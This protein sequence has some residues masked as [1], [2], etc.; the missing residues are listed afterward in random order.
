[1]DR[2]P[3]YEE[4]EK[5][6]KELEKEAV[7]HK[8]AEEA[9]R[10]S[11]E[12]Y[13]DLYDNAPVM[14]HTIDT[15]GIVLECNQTEADMLGYSKEEIIGKP[16]YAFETKEYQDLAP[17]AL[18]EGMEKGHVVGER[19]FVRKD[20]TIIDTA[21][22][23][24]AIY[25]DSGQVVG[26]RSTVTDITHLKRTQEA[27]QESEQKY[28]TITESSLTGIF[29]HQDGRYVFVNDR[30]AEIHD[31]K[32]EELLGKQHLSLVHPDQREIVKQRASKRLKGEAVPQRY[33]LKRRR[34]DGKTIWCETM[35]T[36]IQ[37]AG[38][39][40]IMGNM[41][42]LTERKKA[43]EA[44]RESEERYKAI[45]EGAAEGI[46]IADIE[47]MRQKYANPAICRMLG[48]SEQELKRMSVRD[49]HPKEDLENVISEFE[50]QARG[51]K[52]LAQDI[53]CLRKDGTTIYADINT[54]K[55][56][57]DGRKCNVGFF[58]DTT[59]RK[60]EEEEKKKLEAQ[61]Q[62][63]QRMEAMGTLAGGIAHNFNNILM[64]IQ[65]NTSLVLLRKTSDHPDYERLKG[66]EQGVKS[67]AE[68]TRQLLGFARGGKYEVR[69]TNL[70]EVIE[71]QNRLFGRTKKEITIHGKYEEN[72]WTAEVDQGQ[73][74]QVLLNLYVNAWQAMPA[75]GDLY[76][77]TEN[78]TLDKNYTK[79][80]TIEPGRY[81]KI[82]VTDTGVG[83]D[84][85]TQQRI[86]EP[87]FTTQEMGR[88]TGLGLASVYGIIRNHGGIINVDSKKGEGTTFNIYLPASKKGV[89]EE[90]EEVG[91]VLKG[92]ETVLLVDDEDMII[93][94]GEGI[95]TELGYKVLLARSGKEAIEIYEK[96]KEK[97]DMVILDMIM[98]QMGGGKTYDRLKEMN[99]DIKVLL[100][101]GY[102]IDGQATEILERGCN[103]FIQKPFNMK[104]LSQEVRKILDS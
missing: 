11:E 4:L 7:E 47:T 51:E 29:I 19:R 57:I 101:S 22:E 88:G 83:M 99:P 49:I 54:A 93:D 68:L 53:R 79:P 50:A 62:A 56:L 90:K 78:V 59:E 37:Y 33:E 96:S 92:T 18:R 9:L 32:R 74:G 52:T 13:R 48:Y 100:S 8:R 3:T 46:M 61:F 77:Q 76:L 23:G 65:G 41:I 35:V 60:K 6:V 43:E 45:F 44:L 42:D 71:S 84:E 24:T 20:G 25:D 10:E 1:M 38:R 39:P 26:F 98:P 28:K 66:I 12:R 81:V 17:H 27:L 2:K 64:G 91:E 40:A 15:K 36:R 5:R 14:Y 70:N 75:G 72:L 102:S 63:A 103:A 58:T 86:F 67:G 97:I 55:V 73:I 16:I 80:F 95:L 34:K 94:V 69:P 104:V 82:S 30:F 85:A 89:I 87:F 21:F 31:Y